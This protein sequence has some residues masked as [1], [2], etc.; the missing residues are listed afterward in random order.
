MA[1]L[2]MTSPN[3]VTIQILQL[4]QAHNQNNKHKPDGFIQVNKDSTDIQFP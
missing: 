2:F 1:E 4:C 3:G